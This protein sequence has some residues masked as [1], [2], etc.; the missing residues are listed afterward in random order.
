M[1]SCQNTIIQVTN[2]LDKIASENLEKPFQVILKKAESRLGIGLNEEWA[3]SAL[4]SRG[5]QVDDLPDRFVNWFGA[6]GGTLR[7]PNRSA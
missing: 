4:K 2:M 1:N 3:I 7:D 6:L 5:Y